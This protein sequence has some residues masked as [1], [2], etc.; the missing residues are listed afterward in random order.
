MSDAVSKTPAVAGQV[1]VKGDR[2]G[3]LSPKQIKM[4]CSVTVTCMFI[5]QWL[6]PDIFNA[7]QGLARHMIAPKEA[8]VCALILL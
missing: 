2:E 3:T 8:H 6:H 5:M 4:Y 7:V 1:L